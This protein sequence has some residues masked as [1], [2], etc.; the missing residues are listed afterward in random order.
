MLRYPCLVLD[1]DDTCVDSTGTIGYPH[2]CHA[3]SL[4]RPGL[5]V[6]ETQFRK[7]CLNPGFQFLYKDVFHFTEEEISL[8]HRMWAAYVHEHYPCFFHG[9]PDI[10]RRQREEGGVV[11]IVSHSDS[12]VISATYRHA[13]IPLP[14]MIFGSELPPEQRKPNPWPLT[15]IMR[16]F[17]LKP[18]DI[19]VVD[20]LPPGC[21]MAHC[22][23]SEFAA[24]AWCGMLPE[25]KTVME[26]ISDYVISTVEEFSQFLFERK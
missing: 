24:A 10:L 13:G 14:D 16:R 21:T 5:S 18:Q 4:F 9:I 8:E 1:H 15:Q 7:Y 3:L 12:D 6:T 2:F 19:L 26:R 25:T 17:Q 22:C 11:C 23:G 20:D